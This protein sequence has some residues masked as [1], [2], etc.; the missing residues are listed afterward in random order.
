[1]EMHNLSGFAFEHRLV[2]QITKTFTFL[3]KQSQINFYQ[4]N[5]RHQDAIVNE[6]FKKHFR[7]QIVF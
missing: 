6:T 2:L 1:M 7:F 3:S 4:Q 5:R